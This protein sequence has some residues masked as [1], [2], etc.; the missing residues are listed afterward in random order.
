[1]PSLTRLEAGVGRGVLALVEDRLDVVVSQLRVQ[2][3]A[4]GAD[5]AV[6]AART[7]TKSGSSEKCAPGSM[8]WSRVATAWSKPP[9]AS[10]SLTARGHR[11]T[12]GDRE[13]AALA[14]V[15]LHID[16][17]DRVSCTHAATAV[18]RSDR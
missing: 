17:D 12:A 16:H 6:R 1:M 5:H 11:G 3:H 18:H 2:L 15:V 9:S 13:R 7:V 8:W 4:R 14:E 10:R